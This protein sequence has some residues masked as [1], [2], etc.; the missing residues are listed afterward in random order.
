M[1]SNLSVQ[2]LSYFIEHD[3][4]SHFRKLNDDMIQH[5]ASFIVHDNIDTINVYYDEKIRI[6]GK[7]MIQTNRKC[8]DWESFIKSFYY[9]IYC[10]HHE[11][12]QFCCIPYLNEDIWYFNQ[13]TTPEN[14]THIIQT[15]IR[16]YGILCTLL[17][18]LSIEEYVHNDKF[19]MIYYYSKDNSLSKIIN[20]YLYIDG[21]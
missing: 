13:E 18:Y 15:F 4:C 2:L 5:I 21:H 11:H 14:V 3:T 12:H 8:M 10:K 20:H 16:T 17:I 6:E 19:F 1:V 7:S 9:C